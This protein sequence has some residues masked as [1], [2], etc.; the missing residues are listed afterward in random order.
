MSDVCE[1]CRHPLDHPLNN[2]GI[3]NLI[4]CEHSEIAYPDLMSSSTVS[5]FTQTLQAEGLYCNDFSL[6]S[7]PQGCIFSPLGQACVTG[8]SVHACM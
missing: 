3:I 2:H 4:H 7:S 5:H 1:V 8:H 6:A